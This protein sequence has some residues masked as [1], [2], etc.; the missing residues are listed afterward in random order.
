MLITTSLQPAVLTAVGKLRPI[1]RGP[2][3]NVPTS[4]PSPSTGGSEGTDL[5]ALILTFSSV[6]CCLHPEKSMPIPSMGSIPTE[7]TA[8]P[9][10][11]RLVSLTLSPG[12]SWIHGCPSFLEKRGVKI[13]LMIKKS[14]PVQGISLVNTWAFKALIFPFATSWANLP[15]RY[16]QLSF[17]LSKGPILPSISY[18]SSRLTFATPIQEITGQKAPWLPKSKLR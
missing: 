3:A 18:F 6:D 2:P 1:S 16:P 8:P 4:Y 14:R 11:R 7:H 17:S 5:T 10:V 15:A 9:Q 12:N 13:V